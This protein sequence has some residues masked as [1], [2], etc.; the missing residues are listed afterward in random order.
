MK[1][2]ASIAG[3][4]VNTLTAGGDIGAGVV[5]FDATGLRADSN[6][7]QADAKEKEALIQV[8]NSFIDIALAAM[9]AASNRF[10]AILEDTMAS[11]QD[12]GNTLSRAQFTG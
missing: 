7:L 12:R 11:A 5:R 4:V 6:E 9:L 2:A 8:I 3:S 1:T 10:D